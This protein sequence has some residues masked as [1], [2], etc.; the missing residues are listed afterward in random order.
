MASKSAC[1]Y[2]CVWHTAGRFIGRCKNECFLG[3]HSRTAASVSSPTRIGT[4]RYSP[5]RTYV[6]SGF[7]YCRALVAECGRPSCAIS[8]LSGGGQNRK[9]RVWQSPETAPRLFVECRLD[10]HLQ[11]LLPVWID[12]IS[13]PERKNSLRNLSFSERPEN[14]CHAN[15]QTPTTLAR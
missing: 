5:R 14:A 2:R 6:L 9:S 3:S 1:Q 11:L 4:A 7:A 12:L 8:L 15:F 13:R 10:L